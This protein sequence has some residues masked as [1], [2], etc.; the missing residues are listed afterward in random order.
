MTYYR[1]GSTDPWDEL[2][3]LAVGIAAGALAT[4]LARLVFRREPVEE[5]GPVEE[6]QPVE[7]DP[8]R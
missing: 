8:E 7:G 1:R 4:Y 2:A 6:P 5:P 3:S